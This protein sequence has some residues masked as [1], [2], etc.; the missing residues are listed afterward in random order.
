MCSIESMINPTTGQ[1]R[2]HETIPYPTWTTPSTNNLQSF[3]GSVFWGRLIPLPIAT[4]EGTAIC[5]ICDSKS[6]I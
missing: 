6:L 2:K 4:T 5:V 1:W 3:G